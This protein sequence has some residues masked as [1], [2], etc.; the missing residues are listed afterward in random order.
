[1]RRHGLRDK[2]LFTGA[3]A[4]SV[5]SALGEPR[6]ATQAEAGRS[7]RPCSQ[8]EASGDPEGLAMATELFLTH[9]LKT[10]APHPRGKGSSFPHPP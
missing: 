1:M 5:E 3:T 2:P 8:T 4:G 6:T 7:H 10:A 9:V